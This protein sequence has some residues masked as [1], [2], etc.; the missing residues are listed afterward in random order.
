M[1]RYLN[2]DIGFLKALDFAFLEFESQFGKSATKFFSQKIGFNTS[3]QL[4]NKIQHFSI[5]HLNID[6]V[7]IILDNLGKH[8]KIILDYICDKYDY[9]CSPKAK[10]E[11]ATKYENIKDLLLKVT[12]NN[13]CLV[14]D[15]TDFNIDDELDKNELLALKKRS[16]GSRSTLVQFELELDKRLKALL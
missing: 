3:N 12:G 8:K 6:E 2:K 15:F 16:Y 14:N 9:V 5:A 1:P 4:S 10:N 7:F 13:G 11:Q